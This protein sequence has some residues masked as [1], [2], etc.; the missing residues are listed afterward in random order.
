MNHFLILSLPLVAKLVDDVF[1]K[2]TIKD[3]NP[4]EQLTNEELENV[5]KHPL[6]VEGLTHLR[7]LQAQKKEED[8]FVHP[9]SGLLVFTRSRLKQN[10]EC[11]GSG[12]KNCPYNNNDKDSFLVDLNKKKPLKF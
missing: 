4:N 7:H 6:G 5:K 12:C 2:P 10:G 8:G 11:C 1:V 3:P 9:E